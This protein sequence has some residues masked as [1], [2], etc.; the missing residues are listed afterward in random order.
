MNLSTLTDEQV[1][2]LRDRC[3]AELNSRLY[4][5]RKGLSEMKKGVTQ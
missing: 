5:L 4:W 2:A 1:L 3:D